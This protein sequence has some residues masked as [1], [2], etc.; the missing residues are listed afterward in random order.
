MARSEPPGARRERALAPIDSLLSGR[1]SLPV[2]DWTHTCD[3][4]VTR[5][6]SKVTFQL[7]AAVTGQES[8]PGRRATSRLSHLQENKSIGIANEFS[9]MDFR[10]QLPFWAQ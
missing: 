8:A 10:K 9:K 3:V 4:D 2:S 7:Q 1:F 5:N 6:A